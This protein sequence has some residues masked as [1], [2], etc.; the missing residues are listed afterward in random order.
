MADITIELGGTKKFTAGYTDASGNPT[1][2]PPNAQPLAWT[3][4]DTAVGTL[5]TET[6]ANVVLTAT[7]ALG[8]TATLSVTDGTFTASDTVTLA[9]GPAAGLAITAE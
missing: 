9:A 1:V 6:G 8:A 7:G 4:S 3:L 5:D 2:A